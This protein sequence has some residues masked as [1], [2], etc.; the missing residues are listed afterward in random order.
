MS[1]PAGWHPQPDGRERWWDGQQWT[2]H[3]RDP[4][5][6]APTPGETQVLGTTASTG[7]DTPGT[8]ASGQLLAVRL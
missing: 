7:Y 6:D 1:A 8:Q 3:F 4:A 2:E 5:T